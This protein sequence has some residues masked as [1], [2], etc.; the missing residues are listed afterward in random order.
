[1]SFDGSD[2][3]FDRCAG[4]RRHASAYEIIAGA[5]KNRRA[6]VEIRTVRSTRPRVKIGDVCASN[7]MSR[8]G[9]SVSVYC[10]S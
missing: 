3:S 6:H 2:G 1:M 7:V 5:E 4:T 9:T 8:T 10:L